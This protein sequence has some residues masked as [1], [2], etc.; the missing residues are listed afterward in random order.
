M[1]IFSQ[2]DQVQTAE[3][4]NSTNNCE[5]R[6]YLELVIDLNLNQSTQ[7]NQQITKRFKKVHK[8]IQILNIPNSMVNTNL[9]ILTFNK[10]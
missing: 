6:T 3:S 10:F 5:E 7:G 1:C 2:F 4:E 9:Q 8:T